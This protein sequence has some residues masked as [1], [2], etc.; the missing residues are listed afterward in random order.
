M[1]QGPQTRD[2]SSVWQ[3]SVKQSN[4]KVFFSFLDPDP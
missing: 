2:E 1:F 4:Y 3:Y